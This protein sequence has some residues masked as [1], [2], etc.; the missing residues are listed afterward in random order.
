MVA[1]ARCSELLTAATLV[2]SSSAASAACQRSTSQRIRLARCRAGRCCRAATK[3]SR[4]LSRTSATSAGSAS[5]GSTRSSAIGDTQ[6]PS[7]ST[8]LQRRLHRRPRWA[9]LHRPGPPLAAPQHIQAHVGGDPVQPRPDAGAS[10]EPLPGPPGPHHRLLHR[11]LGVEA[12]PEHPVTVG[13]ELSPVTLQVLRSERVGVDCHTSACYGG[14]RTERATEGISPPAGR[15]P[16]AGG[17]GPGVRA[18]SLPGS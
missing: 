13:G 5:G 18:R 9:K 14:P 12:R 10:L 8:A 16:A 7:G 2:P 6:L 1:R 3:A 17:R 4:M 15:R 11:I